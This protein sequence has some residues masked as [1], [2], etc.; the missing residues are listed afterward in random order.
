MKKGDIKEALHYY[1]K[2]LSEHRDPE[3]V[4]KHKELEKEV[5]ELEKKAYIDPEKSEQEKTEGNELFKKGGGGV[6]FFGIN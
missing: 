5:K 4:K 3:I 1:E 2:A 6:R